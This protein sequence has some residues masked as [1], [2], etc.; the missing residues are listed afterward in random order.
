M[1]RLGAARCQQNTEAYE[2]RSIEQTLTKDE[3][4]HGERGK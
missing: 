2:G 3:S 1:S 4:D